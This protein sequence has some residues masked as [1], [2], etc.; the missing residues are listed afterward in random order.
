MVQENWCK[1]NHV[2]K[3]SRLGFTHFISEQSVILRPFATLKGKIAYCVLA[4]LRNTKYAISLN[5]QSQLR[6]S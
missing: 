1:S 6:K 3:Y 4:S 5:D 2:I